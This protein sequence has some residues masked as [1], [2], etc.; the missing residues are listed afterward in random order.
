M[1]VKRLELLRELAERGTV[2]AV[3]DVT[4]VTPS[5]VSQQLKVLEKE[6]GVALL[7]PSGRGVALT[8]A[9]RAL[10]QTATDIA[11]A[12]AKAES[13]WR[14]FMEQ[15]AG[16]V[17]LTT[18]ATGGEMLLPGLLTRLADEPHINLV[19]NDLDLTEARVRRPDAGLRHRDR[20]LPHDVGVMARSRA[21]GHP[22]DE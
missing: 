17:T 6:A 8:A 21:A 18:F 20:R 14:E 2:G 10:A 1:D 4:G 3:A 15:P 7:E 9:G 13:E 19:C 12:I 5:A 11:V 22:A 16:D